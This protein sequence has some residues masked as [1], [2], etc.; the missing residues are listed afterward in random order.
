[1]ISTLLSTL[2]WSGVCKVNICHQL[3]DMGSRYLDILKYILLLLF[4]SHARSRVQYHGA[5]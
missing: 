4:M 5:R 1:M 2:L 3:T